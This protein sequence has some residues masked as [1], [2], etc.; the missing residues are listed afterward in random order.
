MIPLLKKKLLRGIKMKTNGDIIRNM[1]NKNLAKFLYALL[2]RIQKPSN[3][4]VI[5][6]LENWLD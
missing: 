3:D 4:N 5:E 2:K 1:D 6:C